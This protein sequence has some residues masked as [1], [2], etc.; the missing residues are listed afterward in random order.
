VK[1]RWRC[2]QLP[3][4]KVAILPPTT[5][6]PN[7]LVAGDRLFASVFSPGAIVAVDRS[8]GRL[9]WRTPVT[10][11]AGSQ[12]QLA[13][14]LLYAHTSNA[15]LALHPSTGAVQWQFAPYPGQSG[16]HVYSEPSV[17]RKRLFFGD[18][19]GYVHCLDARTGEPVWR[20]RVHRVA[21]ARRCQVNAMV[22]ATRDRAVASCICGVVAGLDAATGKRIWRCDL[23]GS[24]VSELIRTGRSALVAAKHL[25]GIDLPTGKLRVV[26]ASPPREQFYA[27]AISARSRT[28]AAILGPD[29]SQISQTDP[30]HFKLITIE[31]GQVV[32]Q[33]AITGIGALRPCAG[34][35]DAFFLT[36]ASRTMLFDIAQ[37]KPAILASW[38]ETFGLPDCADGVVYAMSMKGVLRALRP[39]RLSAIRNIQSG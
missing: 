14:G 23:E 28:I 36:T 8:S 31:G 7:P 34:P 37:P 21:T 6:R 9:L 30:W 5:T 39:A 26:A 35:G 15:I 4:T 17:L 20:G 13:G 12:V 38:Q 16:E 2:I 25:Y 22:L 32:S 33:R 10:P 18:R 29:F 3:D 27:A 19:R 1:P 11:Y 24:T